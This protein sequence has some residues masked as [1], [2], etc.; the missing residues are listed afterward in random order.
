MVVRTGLNTQMGAMVRE[1]VDPSKLP[2]DND[3]IVRVGALF[4]SIRSLCCAVLCCAVL[5]CAALCCAVKCYA[6]I[7]LA[8]H[9]F[10]FRLMTTS[11]P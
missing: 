2:V 4:P 1:L 8:M 3:P 10:A 11:G 6:M 9:H 5:C 7:C